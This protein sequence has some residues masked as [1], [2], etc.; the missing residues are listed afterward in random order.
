MDYA[1]RNE[2]TWRQSLISFGESQ[3]RSILFRCWANTDIRCSIDTN[4]PNLGRTAVGSKKENIGSFISR[5][6]RQPAQSV[7][8]SRRMVWRDLLG[9]RTIYSVRLKCLILLTQF[10]PP[11]FVIV[12]TWIQ[13]LQRVFFPNGIL[14]ELLVYAVLLW[15][16]QPTE[17]ALHMVCI[18]YCCS[19]SWSC[20]LSR[21][22]DR[23]N[24]SPKSSPAHAATNW[25]QTIKESKRGKFKKSS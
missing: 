3:Y 23:H 22:N 10:P 2:K 8:L 18:S 20:M 9:S 6:R 13:K 14:V 25:L 1:V 16:Q 15:Q 4:G 24:P 11:P 21:N 7:C 12:S 5:Y 17:Q 19:V